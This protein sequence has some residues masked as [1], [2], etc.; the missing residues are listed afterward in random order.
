MSFFHS[1]MGE[2][3]RNGLIQKALQDG[4]KPSGHRGDGLFSI[5][6]I[7]DEEQLLEYSEVFHE[8]FSGYQRVFPL[9][10]CQLVIIAEYYGDD[11]WSVDILEDSWL[12]H[13]VF[14]TKKE[15]YQRDKDW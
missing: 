2:A 12:Y 8:S 11:N 9:E 10:G 14:V 1:L 5:G 7:S 6:I 15:F 13:V 4:T 3:Q